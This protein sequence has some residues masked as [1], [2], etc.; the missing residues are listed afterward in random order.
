MA[1]EMYPFPPQG[2]LRMPVWS[3]R[4]I[5]VPVTIDGRTYPYSWE[6]PTKSVGLTGSKYQGTNWEQQANDWPEALGRW[7]PCVIFVI[8]ATPH[9]TIRY[10]MSR[11]RY[12]MISA[13]R[14]WF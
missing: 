2:R 13:R 6:G 11:A 10:P 1:D 5:N 7:R 8:M 12:P 4:A 14:F 9:F 3:Y